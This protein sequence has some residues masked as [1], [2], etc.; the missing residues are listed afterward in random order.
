M[1][2]TR[3]IKSPQL[4]R[5]PLLVACLM[6][7]FMT[8]LVGVGNAASTGGQPIVVATVSATA[9]HG[10]GAP[11]AGTVQREL[12]ALRYLPASAVS[13]SWDY[14]TAQAVM[15]FQAWQGL[16]RDG[17]I[18][19]QTLAA[20]ATAKVPVPRLR[21]AGRAIEIYR[22]LGVTLLVN[23]GR[24]VRAVHSS[25]GKTGFT[26]PSGTYRVY[27]KS[28]KHWSTQ[29]HVW[30]PYASFFNRGIAFH[31]YP[32]VP[33]YPASHGCIRIPSPDAG[34]VYTFAAVGTTVVVI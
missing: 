29:Y 5:R 19:P 8:V 21:R 17:T 6:L 9:V 34:E 7:T 22:N 31:A 30:L 20:L 27:L 24:V 15:A 28:V 14:R 3:H 2:T 23:N 11:S 10:T 25:S 16:T 4:W 18:G 32:E 33:A 13:G 1:N 12:V 26:T